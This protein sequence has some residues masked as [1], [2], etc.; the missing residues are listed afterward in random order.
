MRLNTLMTFVEVVSAGGFTAAAKRTGMPRSTVSL[1]IQM[2]EEDLGVRLFKRSTRSITL[3]EDGHDLFTATTGPL[4]MLVNALDDVRSEPGLLKGRIRMTLPSDLPESGVALAIASFKEMHPNVCFDLIRTNQTLN[5]IEENIDIALGVGPGRSQTAVERRVA[6]VDWCFVGP[7]SVSEDDA[8]DRPLDIPAFI[9]P[10][11][12]LRTV[13]EDRVLGGAALPEG[14]LTVNDHRMALALA[15]AGV[16]TALIPR[17][18]CRTA[19]VA[20]SAHEV[21]PDAIRGTTPLKLVFPTRSDITARVRSF[22]DHLIEHIR[23]Q[24]QD[25]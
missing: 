4:D 18:L 16:G 20:G 11:S 12:A 3:T 14:A 17:G 19:L 9:S 8:V 5:L 24:E 25:S 22:A 2:L 7:Q 10:K 21:L 15:M 23:G 6:D 1:H 13:L